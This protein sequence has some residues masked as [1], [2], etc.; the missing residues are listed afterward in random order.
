MMKYRPT[1]INRSL[2]TCILLC[3][4]LCMC[5]CVCACVERDE[6]GVGKYTIPES[7]RCCNYDLQITVPVLFTSITKSIF[8]TKDNAFRVCF[9]K[10]DCLMHDLVAHSDS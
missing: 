6:I 3:V 8:S 7:S 9:I 10:R 2:H 5:M 4:C 1:F